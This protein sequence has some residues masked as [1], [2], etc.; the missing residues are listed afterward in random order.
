MTFFNIVEYF[1]LK[2]AFKIKNC[3]EQ[4]V[5]PLDSLAYLS[6]SQLRRATWSTWASFNLEIWKTIFQGFHS[7]LRKQEIMIF[8]GL[9]WASQS[10]LL[11]AIFC[12]ISAIVSFCSWF[13]CLIFKQ[14]CSP[15]AFNLRTRLRRSFFWWWK[16]QLRTIGFGQSWVA[17]RFPVCLHRNK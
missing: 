16:G 15:F 11:S 1:P 2:K 9:T 17:K 14:V 8:L 10:S 4:I 5:S 3:I 12:S 7:L 13:S 6:M